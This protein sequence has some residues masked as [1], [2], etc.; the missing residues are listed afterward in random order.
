MQSST[1]LLFSWNV[2]LVTWIGKL[3]ISCPFITFLNVMHFR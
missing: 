2:R 3:L 1:F